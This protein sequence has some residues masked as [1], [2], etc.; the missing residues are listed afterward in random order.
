MHD[1]GDPAE[2]IEIYREGVQPGRIGRLAP[3]VTMQHEDF[4]AGPAVDTVDDECT[5]RW[6]ALSR[7]LQ[8]RRDSF[9]QRAA[10][11]RLSPFIHACSPMCT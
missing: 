3:D 2:V 8:A 4:R 5:A 10:P 9:R 1:C 7:S 11:K 6:P